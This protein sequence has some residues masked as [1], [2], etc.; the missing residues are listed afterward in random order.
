[1]AMM[2][3]SVSQHWKGCF[4]QMKYVGTLAI[5][6]QKIVQFV[7]R[8]KVLL[9]FCRSNLYKLFHVHDDKIFYDDV[10]DHK[11]TITGP[12]LTYYISK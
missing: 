6:V 4:Q 10:E 7:Y 5:N 11:C 12:L 1:M 9:E 3:Q 2:N 8:L